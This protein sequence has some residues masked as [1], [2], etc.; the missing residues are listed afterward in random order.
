MHGANDAMGIWIW[1]WAIAGGVAIVNLAFAYG[2][3]VDARMLRD[4]GGNVELAPAWAWI[5]ATAVM[6]PMMAVLYWL[7]HRSRMAGSRQQV[8]PTSSGE[9]PLGELF[10]RNRDFSQPSRAKR[11]RKS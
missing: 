1:I 3:A 2:V 6:G 7:V 8:D 10:E 4:D 11:K 5:L 9:D